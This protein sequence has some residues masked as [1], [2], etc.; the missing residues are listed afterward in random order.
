MLPVTSGNMMGS[1]MEARNLTRCFTLI[2]L[3]SAEKDILSVDEDNLAQLGAYLQS[4]VR[5]HGRSF[6]NNRTT[7]RA[8]RKRP[9][10]VS[11][12]PRPTAVELGPSD[13]DRYALAVL[14]EGRRR[15]RTAC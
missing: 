14:E 11:D 9:D 10:L 3:N 5:R 7:L 15:T 13:V 6:K 4:H 2:R 8:A 12:D 1:P